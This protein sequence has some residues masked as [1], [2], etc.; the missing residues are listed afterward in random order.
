MN[1]P[2]GI[3]A[4]G[5]ASGPDVPC[6]M[7]M[8]PRRRDL[9]A[10]SAGVFLFVSIALPALAAPVVSPGSHASGIVRVQAAS[11][12]AGEGSQRTSGEGSQGAQQAAGEGS[13]GAE[14]YRRD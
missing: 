9:P 12:A 8:V 4:T 10:A 5:V 3:A 6:P 13:Q 2:M 7:N 1:K 14:A 11:P